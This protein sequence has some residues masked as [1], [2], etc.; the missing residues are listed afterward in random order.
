MNPNGYAGSTLN[1]F[2]DAGPLEEGCDLMT[3][4]DRVGGDHSIKC[5]RCWLCTR[6]TSDGDY[7]NVDTKDGAA[8][9]CSNCYAKA[10]DGIDIPL[11]YTTDEPEGWREGQPEFNGAFGG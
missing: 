11:D 4:T 3:C 6:D 2:Q 8:R 5:E 10:D 7:V 1:Q 9:V